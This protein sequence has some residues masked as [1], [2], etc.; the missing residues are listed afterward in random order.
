MNEV[1]KAQLAE[2]HSLANNTKQL[3]KIGWQPGQ[4]GNPKGRPNKSLL[5]K[6][7]DSM[8]NDPNFVIPLV[9]AIKKRTQSAGMAGVLETKEV[10]NRVDGPVRQEIEVTGILVNMSDSDLDARLLK[11]MQSPD[12]QTL[13]IDRNK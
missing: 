5:L 9:K 11:L 3:R 13:D 4:S 8:A 12:T 1:A 10:L 2:E 6:A 7:I